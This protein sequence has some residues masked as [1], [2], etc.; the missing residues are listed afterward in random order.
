[1][2]SRSVIIMLTIVGVSLLGLGFY[3]LR[4]SLS[5]S[6]AAPTTLASVPTVQAI[7]VTQ[8]KPTRTAIPHNAATPD[9]W[10]SNE[11]G[12]PLTDLE[13]TQLIAG[14]YTPI[15]AEQAASATAEAEWQ[16]TQQ[17]VTATI[18]SW[19]QE[20][21]TRGAL[22]PRP[23]QTFAPD[24]GTPKPGPTMSDQLKMLYTVT[25]TP[26]PD[27]KVVVA[28]LGRE[29]TVDIVLSTPSMVLFSNTNVMSFIGPVFMNEVMLVDPTGERITYP[30]QAQGLWGSVIWFSRCNPHLISDMNNWAS[31]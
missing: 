23:T 15:T 28:N 25:P 14:K 11:E 13:V 1:M 19:Q 12:T 30:P 17:A 29:R 9:T 26:L 8:R 4:Q 7:D 21:M 6:P 10:Y 27:C 31:L 2:Q 22:T 24:H 5:A 16:A 20:M 3:G 18:E